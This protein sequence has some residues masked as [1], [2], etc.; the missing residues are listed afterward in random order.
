MAT[1]PNSGS[2]S[3]DGSADRPDFDWM[4]GGRGD[5]SGQPPTVPAGGP[6]AGSPPP[7][8]PPPPQDPDAQATVMMPAQPPPGGG[9][10]PRAQAGPP[11]G[12][13]PPQQPVPRLQPAQPAH[14]RPPV[15]PTPPPPLA[16]GAPQPPP[17]PRKSGWARPGRYVKIVLALLVLWIVWLVAVPLFA[18]S[19]VDKVA[20]EPEGDR[21]DDQP[22]TTYLIV[23]SDARGDLSEEERRELGTGDAEGMRTDTIML[24]HTG[25]GPNLLMSIPRDTRVTVPGVGE[26][27][28]VNSAY[29]TGGPELLA[30][31][32]EQTTGVRIDHYV[33]IGFGGFVD[34]VDAVGGIEICPQQAID[35]PKAK[36]DVKKGCQ[37][38]DGAKALG[39]ARTRAVGDDFGRVTRQR[40]VV[41]AIGSKVATPWSVLNPFRYWKLNLAAP[42]AIAVG[43]GMNSWEAAAFASAMTNTT[44]DAGR[45]CT[46]PSVYQDV[47]GDGVNDVVIDSGRADQLFDLIIEDRTDDITNDICD[48]KGLG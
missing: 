3:G 14:G 40:E 28:L 17:K 11:A 39:Y 12:P 31:T 26:N 4:Y 25:A 38:A 47:N 2:G 43:E 13:P 18:W 23:G 9:G 24:L 44:G 20:F 42:G 33:E 10:P 41:A 37:E 48:A 7:P 1:P 22:G 8:P 34:V 35:D 46:L 19:R 36:L 16:Y 21:P 45:T 32:V 6:P 15:P 5:P 30:E 27:Q 29:S